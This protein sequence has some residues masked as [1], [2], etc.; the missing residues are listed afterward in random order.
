MA[1]GPKYDPFNLE[2]RKI[3]KKAAKG[4]KTSQPYEYD[5]S[6]TLTKLRAVWVSMLPEYTQVRMNVRY[7]LGGLI[8]T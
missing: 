6:Y 5:A 1:S 8:H 3:S 7:S 4:T 2:R